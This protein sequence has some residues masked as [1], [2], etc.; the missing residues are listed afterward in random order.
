[1]K[2][3]GHVSRFAP[4]I[5]ALMIVAPCALA[6]SKAPSTGGGGKSKSTTPAPPVTQPQPNNSTLQNQPMQTLYISGMVVQEDGTPLPSGVVIERICGSVIRKEAYVTASGSFGFQI[7]GYAPNDVIPDASDDTM[8]GSGALGGRSFQRSMEQPGFS[9]MSPQNLMGCE[10]RAD[11]A[12][13]RSSSIILDGFTPVGNLDVGTILIKPLSKAEGSTISLADMKAPKSAKKSFKRA[14]KALRKKNLTEAEK[15]LKTAIAAYPGYA[16]AWYRLGL[17]FEAQQRPKDAGDAF[18]KAIAADARFVNPYIQLARLDGMQQRWHEVVD[19]TDK[20]LALD[21]LD[22]P[23]G[24][25]FNSIANLSLGKLDLAEK[26]ARKAQTLDPLHRMPRISLLLAD[27]LEKKHDMAG[28]IGQLQAYLK[29][30]PP[31][32]DAETVRARLQKLEEESHV[33]AGNRQVT[34]Q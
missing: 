21:S 24:Y 14:D 18:T 17:L 11:V 13:Y 15:D 6:Q 33:I 26:S 12:G 30:T 1:M 25:Y 29:T 27:I 32:A 2:S 5:F 20:A 23:E 31:P 22:F 16:T 10:L 28:C 3:A 9:T 8:D 7:G 4:C 34:P 19:I